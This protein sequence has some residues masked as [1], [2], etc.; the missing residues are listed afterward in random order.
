[1][2]SCFRREIPPNPRPPPTMVSNNPHSLRHNDCRENSYTHQ[3]CLMSTILDGVLRIS[4]LF[5]LTP[6]F[7]LFMYFTGLTVFQSLCNAIRSLTSQETVNHLKSETF[8]L[9]LGNLQNR[10]HSGCQFT[11]CT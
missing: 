6:F 9:S 4:F 3:L 1:M 11:P 10:A 2:T 8:P 5:Y 7:F